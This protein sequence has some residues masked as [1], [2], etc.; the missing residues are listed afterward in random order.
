MNME[1][2]TKIFFRKPNGLTNG[3]TRTTVNLAFLMKMITS[4]KLMRHSALYLTK[5]EEQVLCD[6]FN[7][8]LAEYD[9]DELG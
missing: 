5:E 7:E 6:K 3:T 2:R 1:K 8:L 9:S 4:L